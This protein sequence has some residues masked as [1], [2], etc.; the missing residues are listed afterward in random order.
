MATLSTFGLAM[1]IV[2]VVLLYRYG[3]EGTAWIDVTKNHVL[4]FGT[5]GTEQTQK[6]IARSKIRARVGL[7]LVVLGFAL[8]ACAQWVSI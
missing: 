6:N 2:G 7:G 3:I 4:T 1:D 8:Q 5:T